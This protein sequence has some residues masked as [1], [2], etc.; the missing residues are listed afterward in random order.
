MRVAMKASPR[1]VL[2][3]FGAV[4]LLLAA[5]AACPA[6]VVENAAQLAEAVAQA[7][8][9]GDKLIELADGVYHLDNGLW[10]EAAGVTVRSLSGH[11]DAV[12]I[13]GQGMDGGVSH[14][15]W[16]AA[17]D[18]TVR[19]LTLGQVA[20]HAVQVHGDLDADNFKMI[21]CR[22]IDTGEQLLKVSYD[23]AR[24]DL[25]SDN[26]LVE[27]CLFEFTAG[28]AP[29]WYTGGVDAH[30]SS[31]WV[32]RGNIFRGIRSPS[33]D[34]AEFAVHFW[35]DSADTIVERNLIINCD[36]GIGFGLGERGHRGGVIRNNM[37]YHDASEGFADVGIALESAS[38]AR[39]Y[40]NTVFQEHG[41][42]NA[43]EYRFEAT[44]GG[45][46]ANN[47]V[48]RAIASRDGGGADLRANLADAQAAWFRDARAGDLAL[49]GPLSQVV[50]RAAEVEG[51]SEDYFGTSRPQGGGFD[52]GAHEYVE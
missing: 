21:N 24:P 38:G 27:G 20:N 46:I 31:G 8:S 52:I 32:V 39:V 41:Y 15:F 9:G 23:P 42:P 33:E 11:R 25:R 26:G 48:N 4:C 34:V 36:R 22:V 49:A 45:L 29:Q 7:N 28:I 47:L 10:V 18:F 12:R 43:I 3:S 16:A 1:F 5:A 19:D 51:L 2:A 13:L 40:N 14:V 37:I 6:R 17:S 50:D 44:S 35:S 30:Q